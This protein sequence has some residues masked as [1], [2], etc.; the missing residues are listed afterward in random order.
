MPRFVF[1]QW[2]N[3]PI[4]SGFRL[5]SSKMTARSSCSA[6]TSERDAARWYTIS[7]EAFAPLGSLPWML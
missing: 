4:P 5:G 6:T 7:I 3:R 2:A 1:A